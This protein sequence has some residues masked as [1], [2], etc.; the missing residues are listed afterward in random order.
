MSAL[1]EVIKVKLFYVRRQGYASSGL[2]G[3]FKHYD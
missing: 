3:I 1:R 2:S